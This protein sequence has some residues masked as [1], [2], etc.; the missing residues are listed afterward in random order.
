MMGSLVYLREKIQ[1]YDIDFFDDGFGGRQ[2]K[3]NIKY[4]CWASIEPMM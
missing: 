1:I 4:K 2:K 3:E